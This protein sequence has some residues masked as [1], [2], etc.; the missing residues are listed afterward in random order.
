MTP[1]AVLL[2]LAC[3]VPTSEPT[4][5]PNFVL[6]IA[7]D[8][9]WNDSGAYG[10]SKIRTPTTDRLA[11]EG[12]RFTNAFLTCSSCSPS[13]MSILTGRYPHATGAEELHK[14]LPKD[15]LC[16][17]DVLREG[18]YDVAMIGK[19]HPKGA[20]DDHF[21][22]V[23]KDVWHWKPTFDRLTKDKP[24]FLWIAFNDP[25]R[26]YQEGTISNPH[27]PSEVV[28]PP[29]LPDTEATRGDLALYYD[30]VARL[31]RLMGEMLA[32]LDRKGLAENTLVLYI[33]DNG[34]PFPRCKT[35]LFDSGIKTPFIVR[36]PKVVEPGTTCDAL[37]ST[38]DIAPTFVQLAG[39]SEPPS[40]QGVSFAP[41]LREPNA[42]IRD[43][44]FAD[45]DW[46]DFED[47]QR[48]V[49]SQ[50][51]KYIRNEYTDVPLT[52]PADAVRSPTYQSMLEL[53]AKGKL[54]AEQ[55]QCFL[56][57]RPRDELYDLNKDPYELRNVA[58]DPEYASTLKGLRGRLDQYLEETGG[59]T[60]VQDR[61]PDVF[62]RVTG[63]RTAP[64]FNTGKYESL[65][66]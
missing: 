2:L 62:D 10:N 34:R 45:H 31:D 41:L 57:P 25:H 52:P 3:V 56:Q 58:N 5:R 36:W 11:R 8:Q 19:V 15:Q 23:E 66:K 6:F 59:D 20:Y 27:Q 60:S 24:F 13:R 53:R 30:E 22:S 4:E 46:H 21:D 55:S 61:H 17:S 35:T 9:A 32:E 51:Y 42:K 64:H 1:G 33:S 44:V 48:A 43:Y 26:P 18:G 37:A 28:V 49:R 39:L 54:P 40:F 29:F 14:M 63:E 16:F 47:H 7:D 50:R 12:M 38:V 65:G